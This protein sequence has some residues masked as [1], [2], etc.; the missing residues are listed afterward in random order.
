MRIL[1]EG[2]FALLVPHGI[3][4]H[5]T[6]Y[7]RDC[8]GGYV[9]PVG[10][11]VHALLSYGVGDDISFEI[12]YAERTGSPVY[13]FDPEIRVE[14]GSHLVKLT[15]DSIDSGMDLQ[16]HRLHLGL[17]GASIAVKMD[18]DGA[19]WGVLSTALFGGI[20]YMIVELHGLLSCPG[21]HCEMS[22]VLRR[23]D[24]AF[25]CAHVHA[26]NYG[27]IVRRGEFY[28]PNVVEALF[29]SRKA[30][31]GCAVVPDTSAYPTA[32]DRPNNR[33][34]PDVP[35]TWWQKQGRTLGREEEIWPVLELAPLLSLEEA[36]EDCPILQRDRSDRCSQV[37][38]EGS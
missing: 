7:G 26:N 13:A 29:V 22:A 17:G 2:L 28:Y 35:C 23:I 30:L 31:G 32:L 8:D 1:D 20:A 15:A 9:A 18:I 19:E 25:V 12:D 10:V 37:Q 21:R 34:L 33:A 11:P 3:P 38:G 6:R 5:K 24:G 4:W 14:C 36:L 27:D 16:D